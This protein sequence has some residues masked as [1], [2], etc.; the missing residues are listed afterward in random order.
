MPFFIQ[1]K[2]LNNNGKTN[3][4]FKSLQAAYEFNKFPNGLK[5]KFKFLC[6]FCHKWSEWI[7]AELDWKW[8]YCKRCNKREIARFSHEIIN[9]RCVISTIDK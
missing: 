6:L 1:H 9:C 7:D 2:Y 8:R 3:I 5:P 4:L